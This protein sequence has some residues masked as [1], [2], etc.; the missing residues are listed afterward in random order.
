MRP[1]RRRLVLGS[2]RQ[3]SRAGTSTPKRGGRSHR[4][5]QSRGGDGLPQH[6]HQ[7]VP[8]GRWAGWRTWRGPSGA[9]PRCGRCRTRRWRRSTSGHCGRTRCSAQAPPPAAAPASAGSGQL[10]CAAIPG[11]RQSVLAG[12]APAFLVGASNERGI[13]IIDTN[14]AWAT[15]PEIIDGLTKLGLNPREIK[16]MIISHAHGDHDRA[17]RNCKN[18]TARRSSWARPIGTRRSTARDRRRRRPD[19][20][21]RRGSR[22]TK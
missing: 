14:F 7:S 18:A 4:G 3:R 15:E 17:P 22:G 19:T 10:V 5:R 1:L 9:R 13:I 11:V 16:Y 21:H 12:D 6:V 8:A 20:R 2:T